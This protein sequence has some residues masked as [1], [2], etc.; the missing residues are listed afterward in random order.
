MTELFPIPLTEQVECVERELKLR[1]SV[2]A[3]RV[4]AGKMTV[5]MADR[6]VERMRAVRDTLCGLRDGTLK[7]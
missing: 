6:E 7:P 3:R 5:Q 1:I 4:E 2:Y